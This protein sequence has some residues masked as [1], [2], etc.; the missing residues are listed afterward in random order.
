[1]ETQQGYAIVA[2]GRY[3]LR[4]SVEYQQKLH[5]L[6]AAIVRQYATEVAQTRGLRRIMVRWRMWCDVRAARQQL[7]PDHA[8]YLIR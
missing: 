4:N 7:A 1:M 5:E 3:R 6:R 2:D 8:L